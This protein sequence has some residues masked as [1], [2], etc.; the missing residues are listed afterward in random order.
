[1]VKQDSRTVTKYISLKLKFF[2]GVLEIYMVYFSKLKFLWGRNRDLHGLVYHLHRTV[3]LLM[4]LHMKREFGNDGSF[5]T[6]DHKGDHR[7]SQIIQ[8]KS[9]FLL[10]H[11][12]IPDM[13]S[14]KFFGF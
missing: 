3:L 8:N 11:N 7:P 5:A 9:P 4:V 12:E 14:L 6:L 10:W 2:G 1:M 13:H